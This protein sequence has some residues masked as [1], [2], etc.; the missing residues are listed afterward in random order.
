MKNKKK[1]VFGVVLALALSLMA[2]AGAQSLGGVRKVQAATVVGTPKLVSAT[3]SGTS[4]VTV[5]W[6]LAGRRVPGL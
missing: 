1:I 5:K 6:R 3:A 4:K 2:P